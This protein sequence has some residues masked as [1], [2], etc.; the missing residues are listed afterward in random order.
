M[1]PGVVLNLQMDNPPIPKI[2][3]KW[4]PHA[5][6]VSLDAEMPGGQWEAT[7]VCLPYS[8]GQV[9]SPPT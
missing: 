5:M 3:G 1:R 8:S 4:L 7:L 9:T 2:N 6:N